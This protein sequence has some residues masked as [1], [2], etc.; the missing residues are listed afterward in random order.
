MPHVDIFE[1]RKFAGYFFSICE[2][3]TVHMGKVNDYLGIDLDYSDQVMVKFSTIRYLDSVLQEFPDNLGATEANP[4]SYHLFNVRDD[5]E[6]R[7]LPYNQAQTFQHTVEQL[8]S[9]SDRSRQ[10]IHTMV[11]FLIIHVNK[12][13]KDDWVKLKHVLN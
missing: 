4:A 3:I 6:T 12:P 2:G 10:Y 1:T 11:S 13:D 8:L 5:R 9:M 7:Y